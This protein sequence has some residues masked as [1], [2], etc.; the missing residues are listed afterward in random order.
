MRK[1]ALIILDGWGIGEEKPNN[2]IH[3]AKTPFFD[4]I[5]S[6]YPHTQLQASGQ[7]V[8]LPKGQIGGSEVG[9]LTI[10]AGRV[11]YQQLPRI[12]NSIESAEGSNGILNIHNFAKFLEI[13]KQKTTHLVGLI[14]PGGVHSH[15]DHLI[16]LL[17]IMKKFGCHPPV[18][19]FISDGRDTSPTSGIKS[20]HRL[21]KH[22]KELEFGSI[23]TLSGRFYAMDR[24]RNMDRTGM[25]VNIIAGNRIGKTHSRH[26]SLKTY[27]SLINSFEEAYESKTTDEFILPVK[28]D[29]HY[30]GISYDEAIFF[31]NFRSDRM[32]QLIVALQEKTSLPNDRIFTMTKY[33]KSYQY[34]VIFEKETVSDTIGEVLSKLNMKQLKAAETEKAPHVTYFFNGGVEQIFHGEVRTVAES[35]KVRHD[36]MPEM[37]TVEIHKNIIREVLTHHP[38]FILVNFAN[39]DMVGHTGNF[40]AVVHGVESVDRELKKLCDFLTSHNYICLITADHGNADI[41]YDLETKEPHTAHTLNPVPF[42]IY[43]PASR[44]NQ[45]LKLKQHPSNGLSLIAGTALELMEIKHKHDH[46]SS[47]ISK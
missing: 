8:G 3:I 31:F 14:S 44:S 37:K 24:D 32:K 16:K 22:L 20:A 29:P 46:F 25:A 28:I 45:H 40:N 33:D 1:L 43:D 21:V 39:P 6:H 10:G 26:N 41:M 12:N 27:D 15:E 2:A 23:A 17:V 35:N 42:I 38:E 18:I 34:E 47:L 11:M 19:H 5:W 36:E 13:A 30:S 7:Y 4:Q 9:H